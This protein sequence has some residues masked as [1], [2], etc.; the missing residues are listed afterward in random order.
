MQRKAPTR[1]CIS[2]GE[3]SGKRTLVRIVR[4]PEGEVRLDETGR[5]AGRGAYV[6]A[7]RAC[8]ERAMKRKA[9]AARLKTSVTPAAAQALEEEFGC[10]LAKLATMQEGD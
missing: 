7:N 5:A 9:F 2:C 4:T 8:F 6:C 10:L 1:T 3:K